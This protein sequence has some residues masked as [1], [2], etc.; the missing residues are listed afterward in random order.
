[1]AQRELSNG[2]KTVRPGCVGWEIIGLD[3]NQIWHPISPP[4]GP[5]L[6]EKNGRIECNESFPTTF[7]TSLKMAAQR[8][9]SNNLKN[10]PLDGVVSKILIFKFFFLIFHKSPYLC[11]YWSECGGQDMGVEVAT[12]AFQEP[13]ER[14]AGWRSFRDINFQS[15]F[16]ISHKSP[17]LGS[18]W[19][20]P[21]KQDMGVEGAT[22]AF[23]GPKELLHK[24]PYLCSYWSDPG[25]EDMGVECATIAF[26]GSKEH[27]AR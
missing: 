15:F 26:Q 5:T 14:P 18:Y 11:S 7:R 21:C 27:A 17:Y 19:S 22:I 6:P 2:L 12:I 13:E 24:S 25:G 10:V 20:D 23:Q 4:I 1:M 8:E 3:S 16:L 9:F